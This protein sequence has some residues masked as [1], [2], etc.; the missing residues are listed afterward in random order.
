M[1][2]PLRDCLTIDASE[3]FFNPVVT[4][5]TERLL[6]NRIIGLICPFLPPRDL[7]KC[8]PIRKMDGRGGGDRKLN[9]LSQVLSC[10]RRSTAALLP[11]G[12]KWGQVL[13]PTSTR[14]QTGLVR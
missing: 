7:Y 10:Q 11:I 14:G 3:R 9:L 8:P 13:R 1:C 5:V 6:T 12:V 2:V 4:R